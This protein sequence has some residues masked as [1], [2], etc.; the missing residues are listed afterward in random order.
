MT[1]KMTLATA[2]KDSKLVSDKYIYEYIFNMSEDQWLQ[3]R[4]NVIEDIKLRFR[5]NQIEQEGNDPAITGISYGTPHDLA[6]VHMSSNDV[7]EKD[8][9][10]RP[11]EGIKFGQ[12]KNA[13]GWDPTGIKGIKQDFKSGNQSTTFQPDPR[14]KP[15]QTS[16]ATENITRNM[17]SKRYGI[18]NETLNS[19]SLQDPDSGTMLDENNIL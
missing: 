4:T 12:H 16:I 13:F 18:I 3:E 5:Q 1:E 6:T 11:P 8:K 10:G 14:F 2:M 7:E 9:G 17:K 19:D 15:R